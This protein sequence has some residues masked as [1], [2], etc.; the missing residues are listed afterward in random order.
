MG[1][2]RKGTWDISEATRL[3]SRGSDL[4]KDLWRRIS[5]PNY[6]KP[7]SSPWKK[8]KKEREEERGKKYKKGEGRNEA[9]TGGK[10]E[11]DIYIYSIANVLLFA[12]SHLMRYVSGLLSPLI[13]EL[14]DGRAQNYMV[15]EGVESAVSKGGEGG[16]RV[17]L[18]PIVPRGRLHSDTW[19]RFEGC[20]FPAFRE[21]ART[22]RVTFCRPHSPPLPAC[23][24][25]LALRNLRLPFTCLGHFSVFPSPSQVPPCCLDSAF[26]LHLQL[27]CLF[28]GIDFPAKRLFPLRSRNFSPLLSLLNF[29][30]N[31][32]A[33]DSRGQPVTAHAVWRCWRS[34]LGGQA[35][36]L[37]LS[38][39][40][41]FEGQSG[42]PSRLVH[43]SESIKIHPR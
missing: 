24:S 29:K 8:K 13:S 19:F 33:L 20:L 22:V 4:G 14:I 5:F 32:Q 2:I 35:P 26:Y 7:F 10:R 23:L 39:R 34:S 25:S 41:R 40:L 1:S 11:T 43:T 42:T 21:E 27:M 30:S 28:S 15:D 6:F 31:S 16:L 37:C 17:Y 12:L 38:L 18:L 36:N 3:W 9:K